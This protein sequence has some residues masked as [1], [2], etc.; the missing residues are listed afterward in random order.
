MIAA[1]YRR[2]IAAWAALVAYGAGVGA[3]LDEPALFHANAVGMSVAT[4]ANLLN[5]GIRTNSAWLPR[6][7]QDPRPR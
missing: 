1:R 2:S 4:I 3:L 6:W 5:G 7:L